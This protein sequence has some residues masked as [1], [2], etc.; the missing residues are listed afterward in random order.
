MQNLNFILNEIDKILGML[1]RD[2]E[3]KLVV[4]TFDK[5][6]SKRL[7]KRKRVRHQSPATSFVVIFLALVF[8][9]HLGP[10][11]WDQ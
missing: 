11:Q 10:V 7:T 5:D 1:D 3:L 8:F 6:L 2:D 9:H 4:L